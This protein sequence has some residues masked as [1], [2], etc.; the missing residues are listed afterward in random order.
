MRAS[1]HESLARL[2][3]CFP[4]SIHCQL[5][6]LLPS[7]SPLAG[8]IQSLLLVKQAQTRSTRLDSTLPLFYIHSG[9]ST[10]TLFLLRHSIVFLSP[11][12]PL[13]PL[14]SLPHPTQRL[15]SIPLILSLLK[16]IFL[17]HLRPHRAPYT[18]QQQQQQQQ[19]HHCH[20]HHHHHHQQWRGVWW[21]AVFPSCTCYF[22][23]PKPNP[24]QKSPLQANAGDGSAATPR[25]ASRSWQEY[26]GGQPSLPSLSTG[27]VTKRAEISREFRNGMPRRRV[28]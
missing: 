20:Y 10:T 5:K 18:Q 22:N 2:L 17:S 15:L 1:R 12:S 24:V 6:S 28:A 3:L 4:L 25:R 13:L 16:I 23:V 26:S 14:Y 11:Q 9:N 19:H 27:A 8:A 7:R 21:G